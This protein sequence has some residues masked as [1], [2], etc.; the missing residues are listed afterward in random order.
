MV[1]KKLF[2]I[3]FGG[4]VYGAF[5]GYAYRG[6]LKGK[7][8]QSGL[9]MGYAFTIVSIPFSD[10]LFLNLSLVFRTIIVFAIIYIFI[11]TR[12]KS[13]ITSKRN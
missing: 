8:I 4:L 7:L 2:G 9:Y 11:N 1:N 5:F 12:N 3:V 6:Y 10:L 13:L